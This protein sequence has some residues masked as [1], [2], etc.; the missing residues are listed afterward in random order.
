MY[1]FFHVFGKE[2][3]TYGLC[4][5]VGIAIAFLIA[6]LDVRKRKLN[7]YNLIIIATCA[8]F[9]GLIGARVLFLF[10]SAEGGIKGV[11]DRVLQGDFTDITQGGLVF[12]G[13]LIGGVA[14]TLIGKKIACVK[15]EFS[16]YCSAAILALPIGHACG[17]VG[18]HLAGCCYG[19][20]Y[21]GRFAVTFPGVPEP[22][23]PVQLT[24]AGLNVVLFLILLGLSMLKRPGYFMVY[25]Y[26]V[27]YAIERFS[28]EFLRGDEIR[29]IANGLSTSQ[30]ISIVLFV[31]GAA[32]IVYNLVRTKKIDECQTE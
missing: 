2:I 24:E 27:L 4:M 30:W 5:L 19:A 7:L 13:G 9:T 11:I 21:D 16:G 6:Y 26:L 32:G 8:L 3:P 1:P 23:F 10:V 25:A 20:P 12:Y 28:L 22:R 18:C 14:G 31:I 29:G 15:K 17:R